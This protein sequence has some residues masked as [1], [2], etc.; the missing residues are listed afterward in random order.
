MHYNRTYTKKGM[1]GTMNCNV[2]GSSDVKWNHKPSGNHLCGSHFCIAFN[3][4]AHMTAI[5]PSL[6]GELMVGDT[7]PPYL[8]PVLGTE[9]GEDGRIHL[10]AMGHIPGGTLLI[11]EPVLYF[12]VPLQVRTRDEMMMDSNVDL[13]KK[14]VFRFSI[15]KDRTKMFGET[16]W[17]EDLWEEPEGFMKARWSNMMDIHQKARD[18]EV[19]EFPVGT[20]PIEETL[21]M[22]DVGPLTAGKD[23]MMKLGKVLN[24]SMSL[25]NPSEKVMGAYVSLCEH[26]YAP[27]ASFLVHWGMRRRMFMDTQRLQVIASTDLKKGDRITLRKVGPLISSLNNRKARER[28]SG[29]RAEILDTERAKLEGLVGMDSIIHIQDAKVSWVSMVQAERD[30]WFKVKETI[31]E[32]KVLGI[33][34]IG[35]SKKKKT[36]IKVEVMRNEVAMMEFLRDHSYFRLMPDLDKRLLEVTRGNLPSTLILQVLD[37]PSKASPTRG[38]KPKSLGNLIRE[39][40]GGHGLLGLLAGG[41]DEEVEAE[42]RFFKKNLPIGLHHSN[43]MVLKTMQHLSLLMLS[44]AMFISELFK[45]PTR[46]YA[47]INSDNFHFPG[48]SRAQ[49]RYNA[50]YKGRR[51]GARLDVSKAVWFFPVIYKLQQDQ[52]IHC[53][54][55]YHFV[56]QYL[57]GISALTYKFDMERRVVGQIIA[58]LENLV[59]T[60]T[61]SFVSFK[62]PYPDLSVVLLKSASAATKLNPKILN[63][64]AEDPPTIGVPEPQDKEDEPEPTFPPIDPLVLSPEDQ[65]RLDRLMRE[66]RLLLRLEEFPRENNQPTILNPRPRPQG[67]PDPFGGDFEIKF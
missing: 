38:L 32:E 59:D 22:T 27:T 12:G 39:Y 23:A 31:F 62:L 5:R 17:S 40:L 50:W 65:A 46:M 21:I 33:Q 24:N 56:T 66:R 48:V 37:S 4:A 11:D 57:D 16:S 14:G 60:T 51:R 28:Y 63:T 61:K 2:C 45:D 30:A 13:I 36:L 10:V 47:Y 67:A 25:G 43:W 7:H 19:L 18:L 41:T 34:R 54:L 1:S 29:F 20:A 52:E 35:S 9:L 44:K 15:P 64:L 42:A 49:K 58:H 53:F 6:I 55:G 8:C 3:K 26:S